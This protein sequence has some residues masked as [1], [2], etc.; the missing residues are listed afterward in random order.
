M[1]VKEMY[2]YFTVY[3][4]F[5]GTLSSCQETFSLTQ[6]DPVAETLKM[7]QAAVKASVLTN[8]TLGCSFRVLEQGQLLAPSS[9]PHWGPQKIDAGDAALST[10]SLGP[11]ICLHGFSYH[12]YA[13]NTQLCVSFFVSPG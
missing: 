9:A 10:I 11:L 5:L 4:Y 6:I 7:A 1:C 2:I 8:L 3:L 13:D 12:C